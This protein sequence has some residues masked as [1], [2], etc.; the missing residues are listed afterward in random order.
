MSPRE[1]AIGAILPARRKLALPGRAS[2]TFAIALGLFVV[3]A[4]ALAVNLT[5]QG[6]SFS[7]VEHTNGVIRTVSAVERGILEAESGERGYLLTGEKSYLDSYA[8]SQADVAKLL[9]AA[10]QAVSDNPSQVQRLD[11]LRPIPRLAQNRA[12]RAA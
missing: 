11:E 6:D 4:I 2:T 3:A 8:R 12:R 1:S 9:E 7:W 10:R 5:G